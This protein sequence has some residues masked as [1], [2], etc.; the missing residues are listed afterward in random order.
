MI[1]IHPSIL[2]KK[3]KKEFVILPYEEFE[4]I[5]EELDDY[6]DLRLLRQAKRKEVN[7]PTVSMDRAKNI[8]LTNHSGR[9][10]KTR[11]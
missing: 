6:E 10:T 7:S 5:K 8:L 2:E 9:R 1:V 4:K 3:G 11:R